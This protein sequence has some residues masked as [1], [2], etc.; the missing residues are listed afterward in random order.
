MNYQN[1]VE[2]KIDIAISSSTTTIPVATGKGALFGDKFPIRAVIVDY[3]DNGMVE[4]REIIDII[5]RSGDI[6]SVRRAVEACPLNID[7]SEHTKTAYPFS[8]NAVISVVLTSD[9]LDQINIETNK[10]L[11][12]KQ[13]LRTGFGAKKVLTLNQQ[14]GNEEVQTL[15]D[16]DEYNDHDS[17]RLFSDDGSVAQIPVSRFAEGLVWK[18]SIIQTTLGEDIWPKTLVDEIIFPRGNGSAN[19]NGTT[20]M[21]LEWPTKITQIKV[22][23]GDKDLYLRG[24]TTEGREIVFWA[25]PQNGILNVT[26]QEIFLKFG[27]SWNNKQFEKIL[28]SGTKLGN[29]TNAVTILDKITYTVKVAEISDYSHAELVGMKV[30]FKNSVRL[31]KLKTMSPSTSP[32]AR[33]FIFNDDFTEKLAELPTENYLNSDIFPSNFLFE[34]NKGYNIVVN[35]TTYYERSRMISQQKN[36]FPCSVCGIAP[37][38]AYNEYAYMIREIELDYGGRAFAAHSN[39]LKH[40]DFMWFITTGKEGESIKISRQ[41]TGVVSLFSGLTEGKFYYLGKIP[42]SISAEAWLI[43]APV[44]KALNSTTISMWEQSP[45]LPRNISYSETF[46]FIWGWMSVPA[47]VTIRS[48]GIEYTDGTFYLEKWPVSVS[49]SVSNAKIYF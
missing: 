23:N 32:L 8:E 34:K 9:A 46:D 29:T 12:T 17:I 39:D 13:W 33:V 44:G 21:T 15:Q 38:K 43:K 6:L 7:A 5:A 2:V 26:S 25:S 11:N 24:I 4:K 22:I 16:K 28:I 3:N 47:N 41:K 14:T 37:N 19:W 20:Y 35:N 1:N 10:K 18:N 27:I 31:T 42:G 49:A 40:A 45:M 36:F 30:F 48:N